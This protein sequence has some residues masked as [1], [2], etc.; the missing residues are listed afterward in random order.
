MC[1]CSK[2]FQ[3]G[4]YYIGFHNRNE[5]GIGTD[6]VEVLYVV[7][8]FSHSSHIS[9]CSCWVQ[10]SLDH[11]LYP[12]RPVNQCKDLGYTNLADF[13]HIKSLF[14]QLNVHTETPMQID[15]QFF[16]CFSPGMPHCSALLA[17]LQWHWNQEVVSSKSGKYRLQ[18]SHGMCTLLVHCQ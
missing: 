6:V 18:I 14:L 3:F 17:C 12:L 9:S 1:M 7:G 15:F 16:R 11:T 10:W 2:S 13:F 8:T 4:T 5:T